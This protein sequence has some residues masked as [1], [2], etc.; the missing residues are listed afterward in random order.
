MLFSRFLRFFEIPSF[1]FRWKIN[2]RCGGCLAWQT[3]RGTWRHRRRTWWWHRR[4]NGINGITGEWGWRCERIIFIFI[5]DNGIWK[6]TRKGAWNRRS[7]LLWGEGAVCFDS[8]SAMA[9]WQLVSP[10]IGS[11]VDC[12]NSIH[13]TRYCKRRFLVCLPRMRYTAYSRSESDTTESVER[14]RNS[15]ILIE[16]G[17]GEESVKLFVAD[18][19]VRNLNMTKWKHRY[20]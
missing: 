11:Q 9:C 14:G 10:E 17:R 8:K 2:R 15:L 18:D 16:D 1:P 20:L 7:R 12:W 6:S 13:L 3:S 19:R 4:R 5:W